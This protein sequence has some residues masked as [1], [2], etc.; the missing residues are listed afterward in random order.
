[1][2]V[3]MINGSPHSKGNTAIALS[4]LEKTF[5]KNG[6]ETEIIHIGNKGSI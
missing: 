5:A 3:L 1:M 4:E 6:I 2:K